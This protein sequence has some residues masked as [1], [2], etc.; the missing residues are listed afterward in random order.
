MTQELAGA[1]YII[2]VVAR[3]LGVRIEEH[4]LIFSLYILN[5]VSRII[6]CS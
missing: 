1:L 4:S 2:F 5:I 3:M 6:R